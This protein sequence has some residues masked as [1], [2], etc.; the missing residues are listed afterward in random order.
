MAL[1]RPGRAIRNVRRQPIMQI[2]GHGGDGR[3]S[4]AP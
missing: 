3:R 4:S 1:L 2:L